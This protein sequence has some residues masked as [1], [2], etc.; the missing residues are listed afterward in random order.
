MSNTITIELCA[1]DRQRLDDLLCTCSLIAAALGAKPFPAGTP[2][3]VQEP[4]EEHPVDA[5]SPH[6]LP[7]SAVEPE[8]PKYTKADILAKVQQLAHPGNPKRGQAKTIVQS[9]AG[10]VS[11]IPEDKYNEV[12]EKLIA[13]EEV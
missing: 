5:V 7:E 9:Y 6:G 10:K 1:E 13:L 11:D 4:A 2:D 8:Q 12:M 3:F